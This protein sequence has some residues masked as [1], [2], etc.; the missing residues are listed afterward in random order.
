[1]TNAG[2][3]KSYDSNE[4]VYGSPFR[5]DGDSAPRV[6]VPP[7]NPPKEQVVD[8]KSGSQLPETTVNAEFRLIDILECVNTVLFDAH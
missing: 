1:M 8:V 6:I 3:N 5:K 4:R 7:Y 2:I